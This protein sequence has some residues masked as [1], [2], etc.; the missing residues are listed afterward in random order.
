MSVKAS[1]TCWYFTQIIMRL[2]RVGRDSTVGSM[3]SS[4]ELGDAWFECRQG[5]RDFSLC[6]NV[7][8]GY[9]A[10]LASYSVGTGVLTWR[11]SDRGVKICRN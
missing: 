11:Y 6:E 8:T 3:V 9:G 5:G 4:Y 10:H 1:N 7:R 2:T